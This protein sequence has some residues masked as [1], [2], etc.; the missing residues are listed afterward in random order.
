MDKDDAFA[1]VLE[2]QRLKFAL[3]K[4]GLIRRDNTNMLYIFMAFCSGFVI[5]L[6]LPW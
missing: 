3:E 2:Y 5:G 6:F 1:Q 4:Q